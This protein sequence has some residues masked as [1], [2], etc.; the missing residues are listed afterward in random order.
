M[1]LPDSC[2]DFVMTRLMTFVLVPPSALATDLHCFFFKK[3]KAQLLFCH[4]FAVFLSAT[5]DE[6][7]EEAKMS[8]LFK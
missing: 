4:G 8:R 2:C 7:D 5:E 3:K 1:A 6:W